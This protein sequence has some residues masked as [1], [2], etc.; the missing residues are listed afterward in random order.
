MCFEN[1]VILIQPHGQILTFFK[2]L[3]YFED[4]LAGISRD[5]KKFQEK[6]PF[7]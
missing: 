2:D 6:S 5:F 7:I 3:I 1:P 4:M